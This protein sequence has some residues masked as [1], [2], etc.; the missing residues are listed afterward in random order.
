MSR[1]IKTK[2]LGLV[3]LLRA[4]ILQPVHYNGFCPKG[5]LH[6][7]TCHP[8]NCELD[9]AQSTVGQGDLKTAPH[10]VE[11]SSYSMLCLQTLARLRTKLGRVPDV[12]DTGVVAGFS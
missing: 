11:L 1:K 3:W 9:T 12:G 7:G 8:E 2:S 10:A 6:N 5:V 4:K